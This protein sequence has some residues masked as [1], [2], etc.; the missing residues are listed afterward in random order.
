MDIDYSREMAILVVDDVQVHR[1]LMTS[2]IGRIN[3]FAKVEEAA[4]LEEA[5][6]KLGG[7][8][9]H[10]VVCDW[11][12]VGGG[13]NDLVK[14]MRMHACYKRVPFIMISS[15]TDNEDIIQAFMQ[16]GVD[17]YVVKPFTPKDLYGKIVAALEKRNKL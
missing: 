6:A 10:A 4:N 16:F 1:F 5:K 17:A 3:P 13:G 15:N 7:G 11:N 14:W 2:G 12:M 9:F 8:K